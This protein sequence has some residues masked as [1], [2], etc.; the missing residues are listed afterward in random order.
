MSC[1]VWCDYQ[2]NLGSHMCRQ[3]G[4]S[5]WWEAHGFGCSVIENQTKLC[6]RIFTFRH[7]CFA[8]LTIVPKILPCECPPSWDNCFLTKRIKG[9][10]LLLF[11]LLFGNSKKWA[12]MNGTHTS[13]AWMGLTRTSNTAHLPDSVH[14]RGH[15]V[16]IWLH[17]KH[18]IF[19]GFTNTGY[20][21]YCKVAF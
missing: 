2:Y 20:V 15:F 14:K 19:K 16:Q 10:V 1:F 6:L 18:P 3:W 7:L 11:K 21:N 5:L 17:V 9:K 8:Q 4:C 12:A 13:A